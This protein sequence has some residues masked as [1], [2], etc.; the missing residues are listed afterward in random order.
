ML[1]KVFNILILICLISFVILLA[2]YLAIK[3]T[4][5]LKVGNFCLIFFII[6][7]L[8]K[9]LIN[10]ENIDQTIL[11]SLVQHSN[12]VMEEEFI[13]LIYTYIYSVQKL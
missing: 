3:I 11:V 2:T 12:A 13:I 8:Y 9:N 10:P 1:A 7:F 5:I 4:C 6:I